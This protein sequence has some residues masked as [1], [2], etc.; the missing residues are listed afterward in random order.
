MPLLSTRVSSERVAI[1]K[2]LEKENSFIREDYF[3]LIGEVMV[4]KCF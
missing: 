3:Q 1:I 2:D 4:L